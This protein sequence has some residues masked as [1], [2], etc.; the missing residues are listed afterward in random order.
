MTEGGHISAGTTPESFDV[1]TGGHDL[2]ELGVD[3]TRAALRAGFEV[4]GMTPAEAERVADGL[5]DA[6]MCAVPTHGLLRVPMYTS[7][8]RAG[9]V[10]VSAPITVERTAPG[11]AM[12]DGHGG[13]GYLPTWL[14]VGEAIGGAEECGIG[15][16]A[17]RRIGEFGR[18][19]YYATEAR[20]RGYVA[21]VCQNTL[22][23]I[24]APGSSRATHGNNPL[25]FTAP[26]YDA[27][28]FDAAFT[29]RS[30][31]ELRRRAV[32]G[33]PLPDEWEYID[34]T[35]GVTTDPTRATTVAQQ[36]VGGAKGFG[37]A[38]LVDLLAGVL[39]GAA[40]SIDVAPGV[41]EVGSFVLAIA[42][43]AFGTTAE[44]VAEQLGA[45]AAAVRDGG[46][47]WPG[48]RSRAAREESSSRGTIRVP[49]P[50]F[51]N[52]CEALGETFRAAVH[53]QDVTGA[54]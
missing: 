17:V 23:L 11:V 18:A 31:G 9:T 28:V 46:G 12:I 10:R 42:P 44:R 53:V 15:V 41:P 13:Y 38:V 7:A 5:V 34:E 40:S 43:V 32:L 33:I 26:G 35:G 27:P 54:G 2:I 50:I 21:I 14:A 20:R 51:E 47:R 4:E 6:E 8:I 30:G 52:A 36:A 25:A 29:R 48:D 19:A 16:G 24:A 37:I 49:S 45:A 3:A 39:S 22:P 1:A